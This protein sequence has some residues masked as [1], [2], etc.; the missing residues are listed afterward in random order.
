MLQSE[1]RNT[2]MHALP[3]TVAMFHAAE[4]VLGEQK[5]CGWHILNCSF[6]TS[7]WDTKSRWSVLP[8][9]LC[10]THLKTEIVV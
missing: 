4:D 7:S 3:L 9:I 6:S 5:R 1:T 8:R 10:L 2:Y